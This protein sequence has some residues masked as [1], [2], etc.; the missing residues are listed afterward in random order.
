MAYG[1]LSNTSQ[2]I[3]GNTVSS[4]FEIRRDETVLR[5]D[6]DGT[7][8]TKAGSIAADDWIEITKIMKQFII[9]VA[10]DPELSAKLPYMKDAAEGWLMK[11]LR[12]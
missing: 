11:E 9:D 3:V 7:I 4:A 10:R 1:T 6:T 8:S 2:P 5:I 12:K